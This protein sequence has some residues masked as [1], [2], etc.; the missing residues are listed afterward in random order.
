[1]FPPAN[2]ATLRSGEI[3]SRFKFGFG[4]ASASASTKRQG[5]NRSRSRRQKS[6]PRNC[7]LLGLLTA[8]VIASHCVPV[9]QIHPPRTN[10]FSKRIFDDAECST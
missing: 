7:H 8:I 1:L 10:N 4:F 2:P 5:S 9:S 3:A 6:A